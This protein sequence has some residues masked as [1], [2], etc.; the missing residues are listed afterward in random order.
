MFGYDQTYDK[1]IETLSGTD[2]GGAQ[3]VDGAYVNISQSPTTVTNTPQK[4]AV[5]VQKKWDP[6]DQAPASGSIWVRL[7]GEK[8]G[9]QV[10][11]DDFELNAGNGWSHTFENLKVARGRSPIR[12][13]K[14]RKKG[15]SSPR[16]P[17][18]S[19]AERSTAR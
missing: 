6:Q 12:S 7:T 1:P 13:K 2:V 14:A 9:N 19:S 10:S 18:S 3:V 15:M 4:T 8:G 5:S 16:R 11:V 17:N